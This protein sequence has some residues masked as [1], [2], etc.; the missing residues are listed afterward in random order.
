MMIDS[1]RALAL[2]RENSTTDF[3]SYSLRIR[4]DDFYVFNYDFDFDYVI[5]TT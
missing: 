2:L 3:A 4:S 5:F 1:N